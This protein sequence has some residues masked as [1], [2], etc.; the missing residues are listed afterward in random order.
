M[1]KNLLNPIGTMYD[2]Y[3]YLTFTIKINKKMPAPSNQSGCQLKQTLRDGELVTLFRNNLAP[4]SEGPDM[5]H[6]KKKTAD[7]FPLKYWLV[8]RDPYIGL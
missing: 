3:I 7:S 4:K 8:Y 1:I 6:E 2:I 5:S